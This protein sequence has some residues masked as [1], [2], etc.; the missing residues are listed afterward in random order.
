MKWVTTLAIIAL[1]ITFCTACLAPPVDLTLEQIQSLASTDIPGAYEIDAT[2]T[3]EITGQSLLDEGSVQTAEYVESVEGVQIYRTAFKATTSAAGPLV[4]WNWV[5]VYQDST[6]AHGYFAQH[7]VLFPSS[8]EFSSDFP[9]L[10]QESTATYTTSDDHVFQLSHV[11]MR[12]RNIVI[13]E[14]ML[15]EAGAVNEEEVQQYA[16]MLE[17]NLLDMIDNQ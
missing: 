9:R 10:G 6:D 8:S 11:I 7:S 12:E 3:G 13:Y 16:Q 5:L 14:A 15:Y 2:Y 17:S 4:I 1:S